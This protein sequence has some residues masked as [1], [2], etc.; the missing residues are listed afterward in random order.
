M[1]SEIRIWSLDELI[2]A[3]KVKLGRG[4]IISK[5]DIASF[6]GDYPIYSSAREK[7][8]TFGFYGKYMFDEEL[9][10]WSIDG[11]GRLF[12][13]PAHKF[14][15][16]NVGGTLRILDKNFLNCR[17]L[18]LVLTYLHSKIQFDWVYKA[19]PSVIRA[20]YNEIP[21]PSLESQIETVK[22]LD[23]T[24]AEIDAL[25]ENLSLRKKMTTE[26]LH[27]LSREAIARSNVKSNSSTPTFGQSLDARMV[28]LSEI[29]EFSRGLTY[30]KSDEVGHSKNI[31][32]RASNIDLATNS[33]T[34]DDLRY[35]KDS[36]NI[37]S[38]KIAKKNSLIICTASGSKSHVG[39]VALI[40]Q[41]YGYA[42]GGFMGQLTPLPECDPKYLF[43][44]LTTSNFKEF[45]MSLND[46]T[47]INNL[48]FAD[49]ENY[50]ILLPP[51]EKQRDIVETLDKVTLEVEKMRNQI[52]IQID[53]ALRL[54]QSLLSEAFSPTD[55]MV[56]A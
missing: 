52:A 9:I 33:L 12:Y 28:K 44:I 32:L 2:L 31:V 25:E 46:G 29:C 40:D 1:N 49:I 41:D 26:F 48:K 30:S 51:I 19:H 3:N 43:Y 55:E 20:V 11:G 42:F 35:I 17:Y 23:S 50:E 14:S 45:L 39:K 36:I 6:P 5:K 34:L 56:I 16:T 53:F 47:N 4:D 54:R 13:R 22:K 38:E 18:H 21:I 7:N 15:V 37:K 8:G 10:T 24:F 27:S